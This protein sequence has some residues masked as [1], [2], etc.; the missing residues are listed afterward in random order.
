MTAKTRLRLS[1]A[2]VDE[3][4]TAI[5]I[6]ALYFLSS[7]IC[8]FIL[9]VSRMHLRTNSQSVSDHVIGNAFPVFV[10][11]EAIFVGS[12]WHVSHM[13][14]YDEVAIVI[15]VPVHNLTIIINA[16][17][18][19]FLR[20]SICA[21]SNAIFH[22]DINDP[23][24]ILVDQEARLVTATASAP[25]VNYNYKE[26]VFIEMTVHLVSISVNAVEF[27]GLGLY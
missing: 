12:A 10:Q 7:R 11:H 21:L 22:S 19:I 27:V 1:V 13:H 4:K 3:E 16:I 5:G 17:H 2:L 6:F 20:A 24:P 25:L 18:L 15:V 26:A 23:L 9:I 8:G 14:I